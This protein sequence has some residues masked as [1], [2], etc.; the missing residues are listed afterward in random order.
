MPRGKKKK[1]EEPKIEKIPRLTEYKGW[2]AGDRCYAVFAGDTKPSLCDV[3]H[4]HPD[5]SIA[6]AVSVTDVVSGKYRVVPLKTISDTQKEA[7][8]LKI[9]WDKYF[10]SWK[11]KRE[12][13]EKLAR[14]ANSSS[15]EDLNSNNKK[16]KSKAD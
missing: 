12:K 7:K 3:L 14:Q 10:K 13:E 4:F 11:K 5:D 1:K 16:R 6:P 8:S 15:P 9:K 2:K